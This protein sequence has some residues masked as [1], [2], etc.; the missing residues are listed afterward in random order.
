M[1]EDGPYL[2]RLGGQ[3]DGVMLRSV[4]SQNGAQ[5]PSSGLVVARPR[6][7]SG[8]SGLQVSPLVCIPEI[9]LYPNTGLCL[10]C[11]VCYANMTLL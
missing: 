10:D 5:F 4:S 3:V 11:S 6:T 8:P 2:V 7:G 1:N 9:Q